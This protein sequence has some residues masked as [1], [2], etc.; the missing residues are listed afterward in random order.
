MPPAGEPYL[1]LVVTA[2]ND[3]HGGNL[4]S[5]MQAFAR[6]WIEQAR[7]YQIPSELILVEWNPPPDRPRLAQAL[8]WPAD[9]GPCRVRIIE[10]PAPIHR[11]FEHADALPLYQMVAK[12]AGIRRARGKFVLVTNIDILFSA[13]LAAFLAE[14][15]LEFGR[16][17]RMDRYDAMSDVPAGATIEQQLE[18][19]RTHL[20]RVNVR[21]G[22]YSV[23]PDGSPV[24]SPGDI[25]APDSGL[26]FGKGWLPWSA[27]PCRS[28]FV[29]PARTPNF[30]CLT[31]PPPF[32][33]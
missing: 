14:K 10:V 3:D 21:E 31:R 4:L 7:R 22:T 2:R 23:Q 15:K 24:L 6:G 29:G 18:Y 13:E 28:R 25:A 16:M 33:G 8:S 12:N 19:C 26:L 32:L 1:S 27:I 17:Y 9:F 20:I 30:F 5:R 11:R